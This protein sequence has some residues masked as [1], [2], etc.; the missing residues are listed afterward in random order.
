MVYNIGISLRF[1][2]YGN[3]NN[4][5]LHHKKRCQLLFSCF[6]ACTCINLH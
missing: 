5:Q 6:M 1:S 4:F 3:W 2:K